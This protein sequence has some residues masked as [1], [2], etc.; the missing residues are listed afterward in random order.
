MHII[1]D[2]N[3]PLM[4]KMSAD[5]EWDHQIIVPLG[6]YAIDCYSED[7]G[8][9]FTKFNISREQAEHIVRKMLNE[10]EDH[11][12]DD[13]FK[14]YGFHLIQMRQALIN[15]NDKCITDGWESDLKFN[16]EVEGEEDNIIEGRLQLIIVKDHHWFA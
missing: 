10:C 16:Y 3:V 14:K 15:V 13:L 6:D 2:K 5:S 1:K 9:L 12:W 4:I 8:E 7:T 11:P